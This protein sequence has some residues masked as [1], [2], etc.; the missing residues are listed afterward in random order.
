[1]NLQINKIMKTTAITTLLTFVTSLFCYAQTM[2]VDPAL[3]TTLVT[4][5]LDQQS[6]LKDIDKSE[7]EIKGYMPLITLKL[8]QIQ[9][10]QEKTFDYLKTVNAVVRNGKDII[11]ASQIA[12]QI[13]EYQS[14]A[15]TLAKGDPE[16]LLVVAKTE[17]ELITR[18]A[19]LMLHIYNVALA[20]GE[21]NLL[22][23]K[24]RIDLCTHVVGELKR[25]RALAY[26]VC[27]Q[28]KSAKRNGIIKTLNP[29]SFRYINNGR[30]MVNNILN[31][32]EY[33]RN[34]GY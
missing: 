11:Y 13:A 7:K 10:L 1:M 9:S 30:R 22:D 23:N 28:L 34:G 27:R 19:D 29:K 26:S 31:N 18:S 20:N 15:A 24:Q 25:M 6:V 32:L 14:Q 5:H 21:K 33:I 4:T 17:Y 3:A 8:Q 16:L 12:V 2:V